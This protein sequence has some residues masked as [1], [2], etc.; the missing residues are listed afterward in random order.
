[1]DLFLGGHV[2]NDWTLSLDEHLS[3]DVVYF[4]F[5]KAFDSVPHTRVLLKLEAY[6]ITGKLLVWFRNFLMG[7]YQCVK[8]NGTLSSWEQINSGVPQGAFVVCSVC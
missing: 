5:S 4:D 6:R 8:V 3:S 2:F 1:M 7:R